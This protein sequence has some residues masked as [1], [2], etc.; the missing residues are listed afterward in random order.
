[1][2]K[3]PRTQHLVGSRFQSGDYDLAAI[4]F[5]EIQGKF[6]VIEEKVDGS[7]CGVSFED[8]QLMLQSRGHYLRGG[9]RERQFD[10]L[11]QMMNN[12]QDELYYVLGERYVM[13]G[14]WMYAKHTIFY[15]ALPSYFMEFDIYDKENQRFLSEE[16]RMDLIHSVDCDLPIDS[17]RVLQ[18]RKVTTLEELRS[19]I[20]PSAFVTP[21]R[22]DNLVKVA[23][24]M[25]LDVERTLK[26][27][28]LDPNMEGLYIKWEEDGQVVGRYKFV[29]QTFTSVILESGTHW[30]GRPM[31]PNQLIKQE[32]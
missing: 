25:C 15:D 12:L 32:Q 24:T 19:M 31:L 28:D 6:L 4:P 9:P 7:Q 21:K 13:Y 3:Y 5:E 18:K 26:E 22:K 27:T 23:N 17:V 16:R 10:L 20:G 14:E 11:K 30:H 2:Y 29:R 1:M 8:G